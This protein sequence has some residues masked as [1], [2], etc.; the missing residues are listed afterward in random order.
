MVEWSD[1][2]IYMNLN[3]STK[4]MKDMLQSLS[5]STN[6]LSTVYPNFSKLAT[7]CLL[8]PLNTVDCERAFSSMHRIKSCIRSQMNNSTLN[9]CMRISIE[10][11][12]LIDVWILGQN[13]ETGG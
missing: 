10:D 7:A 9:H 8:L 5:A 4:T 6:V 3:C 2:R 11:V 13:F 1:L 12:S